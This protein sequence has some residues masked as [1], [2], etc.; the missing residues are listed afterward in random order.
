MFRPGIE[1]GPSL[2][3]ANTLE[4]SRWNSLF[5]CYSEPLQYFTSTGGIRHWIST[6][7]PVGSMYSYSVEKLR[8]TT[9]TS[10]AAASVCPFYVIFLL[11]LVLRKVSDPDPA[12]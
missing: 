9:T 1:P 12:E 10:L 2:W 5:N 6:Y 4:K 7:V 8:N 3:E 11:G